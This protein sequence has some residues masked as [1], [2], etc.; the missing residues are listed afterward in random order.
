MGTKL[1]KELERQCFS[2]SCYGTALP[3]YAKDA[4]QKC[5]SASCWMLYGWRPRCSYSCI[6]VFSIRI[7]TNTCSGRHDSSL[8]TSAL[9][10]DV[11]LRISLS[12]IIHMYIHI[13]NMC[14][15]VATLAQ[16][17]ICTQTDANLLVFFNLTLAFRWCFS[18]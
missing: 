15:P 14:D 17:N 8:G 1:C 13:G 3:C 11:W 2:T 4:V 5:L 6:N 18:I 12:R 16:A 9:S 10:K 7:K